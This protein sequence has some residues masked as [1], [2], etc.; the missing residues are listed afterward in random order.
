[1][2]RRSKYLEELFFSEFP[3]DADALEPC[4]S[5]ELEELED[6]LVIPPNTLPNH[7]SEAEAQLINDMHEEYLIDNRKVEEWF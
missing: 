3:F 4:T 5:D 2:K 1:M 7:K 6:D